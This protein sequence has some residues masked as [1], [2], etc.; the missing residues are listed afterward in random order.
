MR[1]HRS[2]ETREN[3]LKFIQA[4]LSDKGYSP[5]VKDIVKGCNLSSPNLAQHHL[6]VLEREGA[7]HRDPGVFRSI[8][9]V[10]SN[11]IEVPLLG[12]IAAGEPIPV[13]NSD[14]WTA[15]AEEMLNLTTDIVGNRENV[16]ALKVRGR[17][18]MDACVMDGD[19]VIMEATQAAGDGEMVA[20]WLKDEHEV[21]LKKIYREEGFVRLQP[22]N[23]QMEP[24][25]VSPENVE[26]QGKVV[27]VLRRMEH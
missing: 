21:T 12:T 17:S 19:I 5:A 22:A 18:M 8:R 4:F 1:K 11:N 6:N 13:P 10:Q 15:E 24:L 3:I 23:R 7:L 2:S 26:V 25:Y 9:L 20:V 14:N 27:A 16:Y